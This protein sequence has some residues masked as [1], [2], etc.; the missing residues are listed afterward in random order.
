MGTKLLDKEQYSQD[1][2]GY[3][4]D[5]SGWLISAQ[6]LNGRQYRDRWRDDAICNQCAGSDDGK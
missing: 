4:D 6:S 2:D 5:R 3:W 1:G